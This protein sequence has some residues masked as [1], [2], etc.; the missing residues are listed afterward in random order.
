MAASSVTGVSGVGSAEANNKGSERMHLSVDKLIGTR[1]VDGGK[2]SLSSGTPSTAS[3]VFSSTLTSATGYFVVTTPIGSTSGGAVSLCVSNVSTTG[4]V[5]TGP[6]S[7]TA[8]LNWALFY[9]PDSN[10]SGVA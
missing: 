10:S 5:V 1:L 9:N 7:S 2:V 8:S 3:V 4:F 6:N